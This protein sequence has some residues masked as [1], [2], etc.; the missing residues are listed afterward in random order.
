MRTADFDYPL[1]EELIAQTPATRRDQSRLFGLDRMRKTFS[2]D[3]FSDIGTHLRP[4]DLL[5]LNDTRV[6][7]ARLHGRKPATAGLV[8]LLLLD[9]VAANRW[10]CLLRPG[11]R[12]R[13]GG[14]VHLIHRDGSDA[15]IHAVVVEKDAEGRGLVEFHCEDNL[16]DH[17]PRIG[18]LPL[19]PY[20][21][22][23]PEREELDRERYQT[24]YADRAGSVAAPTAGLHFT[25]ELI[26][27]LEAAGVEFTRVTLHVG[28]G[29]FAPVKADDLGEH[30]MHAERFEIGVTAANAINR[31]RSE[32]RRVIPVGT[33]SMR[34]LESVA[35]D[36]NGKI[37]A[38][39]GTTDIFIYPPAGFNLASAMITNFH[40][41]CS[42]LLMLISA[43]A[44]PGRTDGIQLVKR[45][46]AE[47][48]AE[49]YRFFSY[50]DAMLIV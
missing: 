1:P 50:G 17:L 28:M 18:E 45:A 35:R 41:P 42:T 22:P 33:T 12:L 26:A 9:E 38:M 46:Y 25:P 23:D 16:L 3:R 34:V 4:G 39:S 27:R 13:P 8:E 30:V 5:V 31:A 21:R 32:G 14:E 15:N 2:H 40:L 44:A 48:V 7:P 43:F 47:A 10:W 11:K 36:R 24:V 29:T 37:D 20:I 19:P 6:I 49:R